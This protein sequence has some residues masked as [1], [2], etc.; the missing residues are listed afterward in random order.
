MSFKM[1]KLVPL[2]H[3]SLIVLIGMLYIFVISLFI[4]IKNTYVLI[5]LI[6]HVCRW[7]I[8]LLGIFNGLPILG[9]IKY[10]QHPLN[11]LK[12]FSNHPSLETKWIIYRFRDMNIGLVIEKILRWAF[13]YYSIFVL[14]DMILSVGVICHEYFQ[15]LYYRVMQ[16]TSAEH[17]T[18][19]YTS[20]KDIDEE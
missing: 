7:M 13:L 18:L 14:G 17:Y 12:Y 20:I 15:M 6:Y 16:G 10:F 3:P 1:P 2:T 9:L 5:E 19:N 8:I 4:D 11:R